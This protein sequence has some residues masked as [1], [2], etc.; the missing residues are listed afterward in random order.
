MGTHLNKKS[1][2]KVI[3]DNIEE[4]EKY[5]PE[6]SLYK[7][8]IINVL[9]WSIDANYEPTESEL[10]LKQ[11]N[12]RL[13]EEREILNEE[14]SNLQREL[15]HKKE[16]NESLQR[17]VREFA[18]WLPDEEWEKLPYGRWQYIDHYNSITI[19]TTDKL[20]QIFKEPK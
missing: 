18:E 17:E 3:S 7:K 11:E 5:M 20:Y 4:L 16:E 13:K 6:H 14:I 2:E 9:K 1:Y 15:N 19:K 8:H 12:E 10:A